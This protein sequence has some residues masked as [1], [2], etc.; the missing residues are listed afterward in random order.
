MK[1]RFLSLEHFSQFISKN[2]TNRPLKELFL[3]FFFVIL[4]GIKPLN[5]V[6]VAGNKFIDLL[7]VKLYNCSM[8]EAFH[9]GG[10]ILQNSI[11][12]D[13]AK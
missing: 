4:F 3:Q 13:D 1:N 6:L 10:R 5:L 11:I 8:F 9:P 2:T 7:I 12:R